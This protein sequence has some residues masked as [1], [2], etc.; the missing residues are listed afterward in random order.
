[1]AFV[2]FWLGQPWFWPVCRVGQQWLGRSLQP[3]LLCCCWWCFFLSWPTGLGSEV[4]GAGHALGVVALLRRLL[5]STAGSVR[6]LCGRYYLSASSIAA[7]LQTCSCCRA[8]PWFAAM[9]GQPKPL[10]VDSP[11]RPRACNGWL[12]VGCS[13]ATAAACCWC[14]GWQKASAN[15]SLVGQFLLPTKWRAR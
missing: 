4:Y 15:K 10:V 2:G 9:H 5:C 3:L 11:H 7:L 6:R 8:T 14:S 1:M 13:F 12:V